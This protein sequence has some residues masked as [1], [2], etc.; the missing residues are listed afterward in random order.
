M[1]EGNPFQDALRFERRIPPC[2]VVIFGA[3][4][5][6]TKRKLMPA[7]YR[8]AFERRMPLGY[9]IYGNSRTPMSDEQFREKMKRAVKEF[10]EASPFDEELWGEFAR[11]LFYVAGDLHQ[12]HFYETLA[13]RLQA[14]EAHT[15]GNVLF[16]LSTQPSHYQAV[17]AGLHAAG[18]ATGS[19]WRRVVVEKPFGYDLKSAKA[20]NSALQ[21][22][23]PESSIYRIDHYLGKET[24]QNILAFRFANGIFEPLWNRRYVNHVQITAAESIGVEG[25]GSYYQESGAL[26]DMIQNHLLQVLATVAMEPSAV[27]EPTAVRDE[28]AKLLRSIR[29]PKE[30]EVPNYAVAGQYGPG[31]VGNQEIAGFRQEPGVDPESQT[32][33]Y[34]AVKFQIDNWR[35]AG[36]PFYVRTGKR[37]PKRVTDIAIQFNAAPLSLFSNDDGDPY[38]ARPNL[39]ILRIQ[40]EEGISLRFFSKVPGGGMRLRPVSMDFNYGSSFGVRTPTAYETLLLD[41]LVGDPTL[42][43]RQDMV[44]ASWAA[45]EPILNYWAS[46]KFDFPN[47]EAGSWGPKAAD[48]LLAR[49]GHRWRRP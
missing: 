44:E 48:E 3:N 47:Y 38:L 31:R 19:G 24:V 27:F 49:D 37:L 9:V 45:V 22:V 14:H 7:L 28:R 20:L 23:F 8:L 46:Q 30:S 2:A 12:P 16:Y 32:D 10:L 11:T 36:V 15:S 13:T 1:F 41:A 21:A 39:L 4:G 40:P 18:L 35:W 26:R 34:A 42:Y 6:L 33:T 5:D 25:R 17:V 43:T 29:I